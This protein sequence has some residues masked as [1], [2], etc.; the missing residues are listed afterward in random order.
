M[1]TM[2]IVGFNMVLREVIIYLVTWVGYDT[3]SEQLT[4]ITNWVF[5]AQ[6]FNTGFLLLLVNANITEH[7][8]KIFT[9]YFNNTFY[10]Y[11]PQWYAVVGKMIV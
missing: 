3:R 4:R 1:I 5:I 7:K 9:K 10:D 6:F 11:E 2:V 8:P